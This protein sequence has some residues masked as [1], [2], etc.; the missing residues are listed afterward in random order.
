MYGVYLVTNRRLTRGRDPA[1]VVEAAVAAGIRTVQL[2]EK[3]LPARELYNLAVELGRVVR[4]YG[5]R[6]LINGRVDVAMA[7]G[8]EG[9]HLGEDALPIPESRMLLSSEALVGASV[10]SEEGARRAE[11]EGADYIIYGH[12][13][14]TASKRETPG[15][16]LDALAT[17]CRAV[18]VPVLAI[19][20]I[21]PGNAAAVR[22]AGAAGMAVMSGVMAADDPGLAAA[23]LIEAWERARGAEESK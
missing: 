14:D 6:L 17:V 21:C 10:H 19:G 5:G 18:S 23:A 7:A 3:D 20:G 15:R 13:F 4:D 12:V 11:K 1:R 2:R 16:G 8:V 9:V 22:G